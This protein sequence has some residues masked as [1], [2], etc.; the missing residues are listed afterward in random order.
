MKYCKEVQGTIKMKIAIFDDD[1]KKSSILKHLIY[2][3]SNER[4]I[5][6]V[7]TVFT[8]LNDFLNSKEDYILYF[9]SFNSKNGKKA[10]Q[11]LNDSNT[12]VPII[13]TS[14]DCRQAAY[15]FKINAYNFL[16]F[17][18]KEETL[19]KIL[20]DFFAI[21]FSYPI[22]FSN[23]LEKI[24]INT[25]DIIYLEADNKHCI[26]H[27]NNGSASCNKTM[28]KVVNVLPE[29][30][31]IKIS[32]SYVV[33]SNYIASFNHDFIT[34]QNGTIL[35]PSRHFYKEFKCDFLRIRSPIIL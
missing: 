23:G 22:I 16:K 12:K 30:Q 32:R 4:K 15:A 25:N 20:N 35:Y 11:I 14:N 9:V 21:K 19:F 2:V 34:L 1:F 27:L 18:F 26:I 17:P 29:H 3:F 5:E 8:N 28:A 6:I 24:C 33:N 10:A 13:I 31:F 7:V